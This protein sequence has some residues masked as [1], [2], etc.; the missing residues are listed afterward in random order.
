MKAYQ[1]GDRIVITKNDEYK[2]IEKLINELYVDVEKLK[3][4]CEDRTTEDFP[5]DVVRRIVGKCSALRNKGE[6]VQISDEY[7]EFMCKNKDLLA[8][9]ESVMNKVENEKSQFLKKSEC[10]KK[11]SKML[12]E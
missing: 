2:E 8:Y 5:V 4:A 10:L 1:R 6:D 12:E 11:F 3:R 7:L 9:Y